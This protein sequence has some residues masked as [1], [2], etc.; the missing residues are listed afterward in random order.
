MKFSVSGKG[1]QG[2]TWQHEGGISVLVMRLTVQTGE[3]QLS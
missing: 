1:G 3:R 2:S